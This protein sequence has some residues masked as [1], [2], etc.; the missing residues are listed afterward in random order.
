MI[1]DIVDMQISTISSIPRM[2]I[3]FYSP[4]SSMIC[5][6]QR[7]KASN[8]SSVETS[9]SRRLSRKLDFLKR[10]SYKSIHLMRFIHFECLPRYYKNYQLGGCYIAIFIAT[11]VKVTI[12]SRELTY[13]N[14][15]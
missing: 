14:S 10:A 11:E 9:V 4:L 15:L 3:F 13:R 6:S 7:L 5:S 8:Y 12:N 1:L 2:S